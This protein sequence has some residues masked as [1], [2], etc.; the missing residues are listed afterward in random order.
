MRGATLIVLAWNQWALTR[1]CLD[2]LLASAL[3]AAQV[4]V[5]DNGSIDE[6]PQRLADYADRVR[7]LSLPENLGFVRGMNAGIAA[8]GAD[9]DVVLLNNDL[10]FTQADWLGRM[11]DAAYARPENGIVGCRLL[12]PEAEGRVYHVG[13]FIE[14]DE[15]HG[16]QTESGFI[17]RDVAQF[18]HRRRVQAVAFAVAYLRRDCIERIGVLDTAFHSYFEDTDYCLR[19]ADAGIASVIAGDVTLRHDQHGSTRDDGGFRARLFAQSR[20][21]FASRWRSRLR[22]AYRGDVLWHGVTRSPSAEAH[23]ARLLLPRLDARGLRMRFEPVTGEAGAAQD[24]RLEIA[25]RRHGSALPEAALVCAAGTE[26]A[27]A[28]GAYRVGLAFGEWDRVPQAWVAASRTL[29]R[30]LVPDTF[31]RDA[32]ASAGVGVPIGILPFGV[33]GDYCHPDVPVPA[34]PNDRFVFVA[35]VEQLHRDAA[36]VLVAAFRSTFE[37]DEAVELLVHIRPGRDA[38][39]IRASLQP[40]LAPAHGGR[41]HVIEGWGFP[42][43]QRAQLLAAADA[44][45]S[46]RRGGGWDPA[47]ADALA[48][49]RILIATDFG[50][51]A[52]LVAGYGLPVAVARSVS[53]PRHPALH[54][55]EPDR[56]SLGVQ[57]RTAF[58]GRDVLT[59]AAR[60]DAAAFARAHPIDATAQR[61]V[62]ELAQGGTLARPRIAPS[63]HRPARA[64]ANASGQLVVL[65]MHRSGTSSVAGLLVRLGVSAG[66][67]A[68]LM[69]GPDNPK[70]HYESA[71]LHGACLA[72]LQRADG[73]WQRPPS[74]APPA[75]V[76]LFRREVGALLETLDQQRPWLIKEPRL[77]LVARELLPLLTRP[78]FVHVV[79]DPAAVAASL[80]R[81]DGLSGEA[82]LALWETYTR[83]AF[84]ASRG[85]PRVLVDYADLIADPPAAARRLRSELEAFGVKGLH[86]VD[87]DRVRHWIEPPSARTEHDSDVG[88]TPD[89]WA[90]QATIADR[91]I[92]DDDMGRTTSQADPWTG[93][94]VLWRRH[95]RAG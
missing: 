52:D 77:C 50:S 44:Y 1:R 4:L 80:Q 84:A 49:G 47:A 81:R 74:G 46:A 79:R 25:E 6:T 29:D 45:V 9:D 91:S 57:L 15:L 5:V 40:A 72:R 23:L 92:L 31:Q 60:H 75:A 64:S 94:N 38:A 12:G 78:V 89:Q 48:C 11:R 70:G 93:P 16:E 67:P 53:D 69:A 2:S 24:R 95:G 76:D 27:R 54:W 65:G 87:A 55:A 66:D 61:L 32:F 21:T 42:H 83:A 35:I 36:D 14:P 82:A 88:L 63:P 41:V 34:R 3:D 28:R 85:W 86:A 39:A 7:V 26:F 43:H 30:L 62:D 18:P 8:A 58:A 37:C 13:G 56:D 68:D 22:D 59:T 19:A 20:E 10:V 33:D 90:L 17:E 71:R 73:D 51:Q